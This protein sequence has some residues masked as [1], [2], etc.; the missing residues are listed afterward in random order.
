MECNDSEETN[1]ELRKDFFIN[2]GSTFYT[3][4]EAK[5][6][7]CFNKGVFC[8]VKEAFVDELTARNYLAEKGFGGII[9]NPANIPTTVEPNG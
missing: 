7:E 3:V 2:A 5:S 9:Y 1:E 4:D 6:I 8:F